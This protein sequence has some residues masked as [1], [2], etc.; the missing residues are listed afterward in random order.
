[1][2][3]E[4][5]VSREEILS[6]GGSSTAEFER[7]DAANK[8][9]GR[10]LKAT[11]EEVAARRK[12]KAPKLGSE[13]KKAIKERR[14]GAEQKRTE[15]I[16]AETDTSRKSKTNIK[17]PDPVVKKFK[18]GELVTVKPRKRK[19]T[20]RVERDP[21]TGRARKRTTPAP[22]TL[23]QAGPEVMT[24]AGRPEIQPAILPRTLRGSQS[25]KN[26]GG[27]AASHKIV[28]GHTYE[29]LKHLQTMADTPKNSPE[30]HA[31]HEAF[32]ASHAQIGQTGNK[33]L[34]TLV[35]MGRAAV[36]QMH[37]SPNLPNALKT[38]KALVLG[39]LEEGRIAEQARTERSGPGK[40]Q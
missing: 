15:R 36:Q 16:K 14:K 32:N 13:E 28:K 17:T 38:H 9:A 29:A 25:G 35:G 19:P 26:L 22:V 18:K 27:F 34:H 30:H 37:G 33:G 11:P 24:P 2:A 20:P 39:K 8:L 5:K 7:L 10:K 12:A 6:V 40:G 1:M 23:P 4:D 3:K 31:A 21:E